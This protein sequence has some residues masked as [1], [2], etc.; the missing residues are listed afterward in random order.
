M[1][2]LKNALAKQLASETCD[3]N[4]EVYSRAL[5]E[6]TQAIELPVRKSI[7][8]GSNLFNIFEEADFRDLRCQVEFPLDP[9][10]P[11]TEGQYVAHAIPDCAAI[12]CA[13]LQ[14]DYVV[15]PTYRIGHCVEW[16]I[17]RARFN[18]FIQQRSI[19]AFRAGFVKKMNTD[20]WH[21]LMA[22][23][24][25]RNIV[26]HDPNASTGQFTKRLPI[27][28]KTLMRRNGG[29]NASSSNR[30]R[31]TDLFMSPEIMDDVYNWNIDQIPEAIQTEI[32]RSP[33]CDQG[34]DELVLR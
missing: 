22:A 23:G 18:N 13:M 21:V 34:F 3:P 25:D 16:C 10:T 26:V 4:Y 33:N 27:M 29:G 7:F 8:D 9:V 5:A 11:G 15:V 19:D 20:G 6:F 32:H 1:L 2:S 12:P 28:M 24:L 14:G 31:L 17:R 30:S